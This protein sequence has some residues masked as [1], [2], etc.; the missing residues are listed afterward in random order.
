MLLKHETLWD[1][2]S[3]SEIGDERIRATLK[4]IIASIRRVIEQT[5]TILQYFDLIVFSCKPVK[6]I[7][8]TVPYLFH[9]I[10]CK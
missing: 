10:S 1:I 3:H 7:Q 2:I 4:A 9:Y 5:L 8:L 6:W